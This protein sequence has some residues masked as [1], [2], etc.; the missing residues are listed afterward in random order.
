MKLTFNEHLLNIKDFQA[1]QEVVTKELQPLEEFI[2]LQAL[3]PLVETTTD[4][5]LPRWEKDYGIIP[6]GSTQERKANLLSKLNN[7]KALTENWLRD[8]LLSYVPVGTIVGYTF[9]IKNNILSINFSG[10]TL[11]SANY[12]FNELRDLL[13]VHLLLKVSTI[14]KETMT[15]YADVIYREYRKENMN[16]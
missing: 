8:K 16:G 5:G 12:I 3:E 7:N 11:K 1:L 13:P 2:S 15:Y 14:Q 10:E 4:Y 6:F 9:N